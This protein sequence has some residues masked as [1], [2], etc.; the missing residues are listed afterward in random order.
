MRILQYNV[1]GWSLITCQSLSGN[2]IR[3]LHSVEDVELDGLDLTDLYWDC[4]RDDVP[5]RYQSDYDL[6]EAKRKRL[7]REE[8]DQKISSLASCIKAKTEELHELI[9][10]RG[11][12]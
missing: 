11:Q 8:L 1:G 4:V 3:G 9:S 10:L 5:W 7:E 2:A 6:A 12:L